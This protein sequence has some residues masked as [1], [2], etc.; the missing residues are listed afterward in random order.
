MNKLLLDS[1]LMKFRT[2]FLQLK[3]MDWGIFN[4]HK[5]DNYAYEADI[6]RY[7]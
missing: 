6:K 2:I 5:N 4:L 3:P 7:C 1:N